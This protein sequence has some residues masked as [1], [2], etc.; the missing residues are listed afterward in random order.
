MPK[1]EHPEYH[2]LS[3]FKF[4]KE[5]SQESIN[6][7]Y[8]KCFDVKYPLLSVAKTFI[9]DFLLYQY[10]SLRYTVPVNFKPNF[11][12]Y[13]PIAINITGINVR[14]NLKYKDVI[15]EI[16]NYNDTLK[17]LSN[18]IFTIDIEVREAISKLQ[19]FI[20]EE[21]GL[22]VE[23][24]YQ[25]SEELGGYE[26]DHFIKGEYIANDGQ[27]H[28]SSKHTDEINYTL[29]FKKLVHKNKIPVEIL[30]PL[31]SIAI[32]TK[33]NK[34]ASVIKLKQ[35]NRNAIA[36]VMARN[37]SH[38]IGSHV[39]SRMVDANSIEISN[40]ISGRNLYYTSIKESIIGEDKRER[41]NKKFEEVKSEYWNNPKNPKASDQNIKVTINKFLWEQANKVYYNEL[42]SYF[43]SYLK[44]RQALLADIVS[45]TPQIQSSKWFMKEIM[46]GIDSNRLLLNRISG[47][48]KFNY[49]FKFDGDVCK[50]NKGKCTSCKKKKDVQVA[51]STDIVGQH[52]IYIILENIIRNTAK[53]NKKTYDKNDNFDYNFTIRIVPS[54]TNYSHYQVTIF[55]DIT[56]GGYSFLKI[57]R[58]KNKNQPY[59]WYNNENQE[60][61]S[62]VFDLSSEKEI[63]IINVKKIKHREVYL[64]IPYKQRMYAGSQKGKADTIYDYYRIS[65]I[66]Q[67]VIQQ[68]IWI[69]E[70]ILNQDTFDLRQG[71][72]G[73]IEMEVCAAYLR[74][75]PVED[76]EAPEFKLKFDKKEI[77]DII[78]ATREG[79]QKLRL[80][81]AVRELY[82]DQKQTGSLGYRFYLP[83][84][85]E[86]L[87][88]DIKGNLWNRVKE[89]GNNAN[90]YSEFRKL[91][92]YGILLLKLDVTK[93][94][95]S[96][97]WCYNINKTYQHGLML[98]IEDNKDNPYKLS[99][100]RL[101]KGIVYYRDLEKH[102][103]AYND[104]F[105]KGS[106]K[107]NVNYEISLDLIQ[108]PNAFLIESWRS[109]ITTRMVENNIKRFKNSNL[110]HLV[111][112]QESGRVYRIK[113][114]HH[115]SELKGWNGNYHAVFESRFS[116]LEKQFT[117]I[118]KDGSFIITQFKAI[119]AALT[120]IAV[121]DER[122]QELSKNQYIL[123]G[124]VTKTYQEIWN[125]MHVY[126][127]TKED[128]NLSIKTF[129]D[130][131]A[132]RIIRLIQNQF[133]EESIRQKTGLD[134]VIVHLGILEKILNTQKGK[135]K[136]KEG[137]ISTLISQIANALN[138]SA[139]V[140]LTS[141]RAPSRLPSKI[142]FL[143]YS[144]L[145]QYLIEYRFK[146]LLSEIV[147]ASRP[148]T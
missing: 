124:G 37:M 130:D 108:N 83:K 63:N 134:F 61:T 102:F 136:D 45:G 17:F 140:I 73:L 114:D 80:L 19:S 117:P 101:P 6:N 82:N 64:Q 62:K 137:D 74:G 88:I 46:T 70:P 55:D 43:F 36:K 98:I 33:R 127:P 76:I 106:L 65:N 109:Y 147:Y 9:C 27:E 56:I 7:I 107:E 72:L 71:A 113:Y 14:E 93:N 30:D 66:D 84:P 4:F 12:V 57:K 42:I 44:T 148:K 49:K 54:T 128:I 105:E 53:H 129:E 48:E 143:S 79:K 28:S 69:N 35:S 32:F 94:D 21:N 138:P 112:N 116:D 77:K 31:F 120:N 52:C 99:F 50:C 18:E 87:I 60:F 2:L 8:V 58:E 5:Y 25:L 131:Y 89:K 126:I 81:R 40:I 16:K 41:I 90:I 115:G 38:N 119:D 110:N 104:K 59:D 1:I 3:W 118:S 103:A 34:L 22:I 24:F 29:Y 100:Y 68:N 91:E 142:S 141:G 111:P 86:L 78:K 11:E 20:I 67:L 96:S 122:I 10:L 23:G 51:V 75:I 139:R 85:K 47:V 132:E 144:L 133:D 125:Y 97:N 145:S 121:I 26:K 123:E 135:S 15:L 13:L 146:L 95:I 92:S 39:L